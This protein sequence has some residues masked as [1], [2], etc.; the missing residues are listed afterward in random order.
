MLRTLPLFSHRAVLLDIASGYTET[1]AI[2]QKWRVRAGQGLFACRA[3]SAVHTAASPS[4][5]AAPL[6]P[7]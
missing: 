7:P 3:G 1:L 5:S 6:E 2:K 4:T